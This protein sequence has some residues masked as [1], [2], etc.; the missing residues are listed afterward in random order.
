MAP[1]WAATRS[2][3]GNPAPPPASPW[4]AT[5]AEAGADPARPDGAADRDGR[6]WGCY[7]HGIFENDLFR[8]AWLGSLTRNRNE[9]SREAPAATGHEARFQAALDRLADA[10]ERALDMAAIDA[11]IRDQHPS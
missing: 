3:W 10:V 7:I 1:S 4:L 2:T 6:V 9:A 5:T 11:I 8:R